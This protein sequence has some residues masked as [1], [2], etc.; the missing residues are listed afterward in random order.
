MEKKPLT[1]MIVVDDDEDVLTIAKYCLESL[2]STQIKYFSSGEEAL[3][4]AMTFNPDLILLDVMMPKMDGN[5]T[6]EALRLIP[7]LA[8]IPVVFFTAKAQKEELSNYSK[9]GII[10]I[11]VKPFDPMTLA[12]RVL[13]IWDR[14]QGL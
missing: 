3:R 14:H 11:I 12:Q 5:A 7:T 13:K 6:L 2:S 1:K 8:S 9:L 4:E 10:D